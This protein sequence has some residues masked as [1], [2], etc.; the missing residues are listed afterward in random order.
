MRT[1]AVEVWMWMGQSENRGSLW[2]AN[3]ANAAEVN[4]T[5]TCGRPARCN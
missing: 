3:V 2:Q 5:K 4:E 1:A